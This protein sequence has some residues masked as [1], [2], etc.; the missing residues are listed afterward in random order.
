MTQSFGQLNDNGVSHCAQYVAVTSWSVGDAL[1]CESLCALCVDDNCEGGCR[2]TDVLAGFIVC[3]VCDEGCLM[4][5][6]VLIGGTYL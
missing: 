3:G 6:R 1:A 2:V 5:W 4:C